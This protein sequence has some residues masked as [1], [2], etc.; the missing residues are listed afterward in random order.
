M[1]CSLICRITQSIFLDFYQTNVVFYIIVQMHKK[2]IY[3]FV[4]NHSELY[5]IFIEKHD[6]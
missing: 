6:I 3:F 5:V 2:R 4:G 1:T